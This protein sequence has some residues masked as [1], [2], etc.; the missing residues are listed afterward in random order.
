VRSN[1][2]LLEILFI[3][4]VLIEPTLFL[5]HLFQ[6]PIEQLELSIGCF[7]ELLV[8]MGERALQLQVPDFLEKTLANVCSEFNI[9]LP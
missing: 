7:A 1:F 4:S 6:F 5:S 8:L 2:L 3:N 9:M